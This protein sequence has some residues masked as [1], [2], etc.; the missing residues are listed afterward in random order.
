MK[1]AVNRENITRYLLG[2]LPDEERDELTSQ[3]FEDDDLFAEI[4]AVKDELVTEYR[5]GT[6]SPEDKAALEDFL[7]KYPPAV[8]ELSL[9]KALDD[10]ALQYVNDEQ[11]AGIASSPYQ[12]PWGNTPSLVASSRLH[13]AAV[14]APTAVALILFASVVWLGITNQRMREDLART[15]E[16]LSSARLSQQQRQAPQ[17]GAGE[18]DALRTHVQ[19]LQAELDNVREDKATLENQLRKPLTLGSALQTIPVMILPAREGMQPRQVVLQPQKLK[20]EVTVAADQAFKSFYALIQR[21]DDGAVVVPRRS[22]RTRRTGDNVILVLEA[23]TNLFVTGTVYK[24]TIIGSGQDGE[25]EELG[26]EY[27]NIIKR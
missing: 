26:Y 24:L 20:F 6:L 22:V 4:M 5:R 13:R 15:R 25:D 19:E 23:P 9:A 17:L 16:E 14:Y 11:E 18:E 12:K 7:R 21:Q 1:Q 27:F 2:R 3:Y 10:Y 8:H